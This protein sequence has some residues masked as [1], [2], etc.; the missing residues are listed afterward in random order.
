MEQQMNMIIR[1]KYLTIVKKQYVKGNKREKGEILK[2]LE[3]RTGMHRKSLIRLLGSKD[4]NRGKRRPGRKNK[5]DNPIIFK[6]IFKL[7][8][9]TNLICSKRL[10][11]TLP[12][13]LP[14][15]TNDEIKD[16]EKKLLCEISPRTIDRI[17]SKVRSKYRKKGFCTT[18]PGSMISKRIP[19]KTEQWEESR[20][21]FFEA[22]TVAHCGGSTA[23]Q[24]TY[25]LNLV[26]IPQGGQFRGQYGEKVNPGCLNLLKT[27]RKLFL[28]IFWVL[29][30]IMAMNL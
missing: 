21:G 27:L 3:K 25:T 30:L 7:W 11:A 1:E 10:K 23:G 26:D 14:F 4:R 22:D 20:P 18:K 9:L 24:F 12:L 8:Q 16:K 5:Y 28:S 13:W 17:F 19:V 29:T 6:T 15:I 2:E